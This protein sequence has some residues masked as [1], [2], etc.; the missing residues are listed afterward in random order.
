MMRASARRSETRRVSPPVAGNI[1]PI[2]EARALPPAPGIGKD[3]SGRM[4]LAATAPRQ[5]WRPVVHVGSLPIE[6]VGIRQTAQA[7]IDY[8]L[9]AERAGAARPVYSTSVNGQVISLCARDSKLAAMFLSA[10]SINADGQPLVFLSRY[11][12]ANPLPERVATSDLFPVVAG[13]A[14]KAGVTF[15]MLGGSEEVN[16]KAVEISL[17]AHPA[18]RIVGRRNGYFSRDEEAAVVE[19]IVRLRPDVLWLSL[20][21]PLEQ[22]FCMRNLNALR[23]VGI[24]KT[25]GGLFDFISLVKPRAPVWMQKSGI[26]WLYRMAREPRRLFLRYALTNPHAL[27]LMLRS[28]R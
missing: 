28:L 8:C 16:R 21:V 20:G 12:C 11:L 15:Y 6:A 17:A 3:W 27:L 14:A 23:G 22:Q 7:F 19:E 5:Q 1:V 24:V 2:R 26:E 10:D 4:Q 13:M 18:L 9:S 25:S